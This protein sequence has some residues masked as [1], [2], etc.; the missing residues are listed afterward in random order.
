MAALLNASPVVGVL[1]VGRFVAGLIALG[2]LV[3]LVLLVHVVIIATADG[4]NDRMGDADSGGGRPGQPPAVARGP[5]AVRSRRR[6]VKALVIGSD[7]RASTSKAQVVMWTFAVFY[8]LLFLL[9][10]GRSSGCDELQQDNAQCEQAAEARGA[11]DRVVN[12]P[13]QPAYYVLLG[14]PLAAAVT[15]K[16]LTTGKV[17]AGALQKTADGGPGVAKGIGEV[18]SNDAGEADLVD[19]QYFAFNLVTLAFFAVQ[20]LNQA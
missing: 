15:A 6:G 7:G 18:V 5:G 12:N 4:T 11:F 9:V 17:A 3:V 8:A 10:W 16:A 19:F 14:F 20:F 1:V 2:T 13:L